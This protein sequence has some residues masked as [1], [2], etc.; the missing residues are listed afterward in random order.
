MR[1]WRLGLAICE[2]IWSADVC[3]TLSETGAEIILSLNASPFESGKTDQRMSHAVARMTESSLPFVYV[4]MVG[5]QDELVF[6]GGS[7]ALNLG[8]KLA[9]QMPQFTEKLSVVTMRDGDAGA[10]L[11]GQVSQP[12]SENEAMWRALVLGIR[13]YCSK[14]G[15]PGLFWACLAVSILRLSPHWRL[16]RWAQMRFGS[17]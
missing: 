9:C 3:E 16:M 11:T 10:V 12:D 15:F 14:N 6:D 7:F 4:N 13:D 5:G 2:D 1:G 8:G 17:S